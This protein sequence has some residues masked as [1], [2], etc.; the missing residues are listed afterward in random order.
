MLKEKYDLEVNNIIDAGSII[1]KDT[2]VVA[3]GSGPTC[4]PVILFNKILKENYK[5]ILLVATGSLHSK[6]SSNLNE[7]IPNISHVISMEVL[8]YI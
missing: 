6:L 7:S 3:G 8:W 2:N 5:K 1:Y 4:L